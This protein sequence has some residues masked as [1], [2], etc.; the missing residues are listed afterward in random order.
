MVFK[1]SLS[2][3]S[4]ITLWFRSRSVVTTP[5]QYISRHIA[6]QVIQR[7]TISTMSEAFVRP[8]RSLSGRVAIVS[9]AGAAG[10]GIG[11]GRASAILLAEAG[12]SVVCVDMKRDLA[13]RTVEM[14]EKD[15]HGKA[16]AVQADAT[17]ADD[18][19]NAVQTAVKEYGR[20]DIRE[21]HRSSSRL[22]IR[23]NS[24]SGQCCRHRWS[25][26]NSERSRHGRLGKKYGD[27][28]SQHGSYV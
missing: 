14:I 7:H 24:H 11:N 17:K 6:S 10:D 9:G 28:R 19:K 18:C 15:G 3:F 23:P 21:F 8:T 25:F 27:Q 4:S 20:L 26:G 12:C 1:S 2:N 13:Q 16:I 22:R 5:H